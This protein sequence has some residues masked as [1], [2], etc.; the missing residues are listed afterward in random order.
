MGDSSF[1]YAGL[2]MCNMLPALQQHLTDSYVL[3]QLSCINFLTLLP[4]NLFTVSFSSCFLLNPVAVITEISIGS[5][6]DP[7]AATTTTF[8]AVTTTTTTEL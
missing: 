4:S 5:F 3:C 8:T 1:A 7:A 2:R 6:L